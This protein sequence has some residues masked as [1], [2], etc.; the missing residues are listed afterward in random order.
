MKQSQK[1]MATE[2]D[3]RSA[4]AATAAAAAAAKAS[5]K[6]QVLVQLALQRETQVISLKDLLHT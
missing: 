4:A 6:T 1:F 5:A 3:H 2:R